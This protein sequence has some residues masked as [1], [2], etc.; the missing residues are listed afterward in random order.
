MILDEA[1]A[2]HHKHSAWMHP[3]ALKRVQAAAHHAKRMIFDADASRLL[4]RFM[5]SC[6]DLIIANRQFAMPLY[7]T[8]YVELDTQAMYREIDGEAA[9]PIKLDSAEADTSI[10]FLIDYRTVYILAKGPVSSCIMPVCFYFNPRGEYKIPTMGMDIPYY[11]FHEDAAY[12]TQINK[13]RSSRPPSMETEAHLALMLGKSA[14]HVKTPDMLDFAREVAFFYAGKKP[15]DRLSPKAHQDVLTEMVG[16]V[17]NL[18]AVLLWLNSLPHTVK[19]ISQPAGS[20]LYRGKRLALSSH[21]VVTIHMKGSVEVRN[22]FKKAIRH[23][24]SPR[25]HDV[26]GFWR[27]RRGIPQGCGH[28]WPATADEH[29]KFVCSKCGRERWWVRDHQRGDK[30]KGYIDKH[31]EAEI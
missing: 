14:S 25:L 15:A 28:I 20:K 16:D 31:Y 5:N 21:N 18:Y 8:M 23:H 1:L 3:V 2:S 22:L 17:R 10:G 9:G 13:D 12:I 29:H 24:A 11:D 4:G 7:D 26:R 6:V 27:H 19:Y 30:S